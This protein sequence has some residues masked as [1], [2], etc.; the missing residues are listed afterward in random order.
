MATTTTDPM[1][2]ELF[3]IISHNNETADTFTIKLQPVNATQKFAFQPGQ[4][5]MLHAFGVGESAISISGDP[6]EKNVITHTIKRVGSVTKIIEALQLGA[7][8]G[9]RG[10]F[11]RP[12]PVQATVGKNIV[13]VAGGIGLAP[14]R[15]MIYHILA[16]RNQYQKVWLFYG[17]RTPKDVIYDHEISTWRK[18]GEMNVQLTVDK[19]S[20][21]WRG[22]VGTVTALMEKNQI[23]VTN[24]LALVCGPEIMI[25]FSV[26]SLEKMGFSKEA[27]Y[28]SMER[29]MQCGV[30]YCGHCL[31]GS[32][33]ICKDGPVFKYSEAEQLLKV[34][35]L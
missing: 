10:P 27:I 17:A 13:I 21:L 19:G 11:G 7:I 16:N 22:K 26:L 15:P 14:L 2:P 33:F 25:H 1:I 32:K 30:G 28:V 35:E 24:T 3:K 12:W 5:C 23:E 4:F 8:I 18:R 29:N 20:L 9:V 31:C 34:R 6:A